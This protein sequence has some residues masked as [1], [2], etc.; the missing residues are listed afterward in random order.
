VS[1]HLIA[2][3]MILGGVFSLLWMIESRL[4]RIIKLLENLRI[5]TPEKAADVLKA[6]FGKKVSM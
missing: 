6:K 5:V 1:G 3:G 4:C 2:I